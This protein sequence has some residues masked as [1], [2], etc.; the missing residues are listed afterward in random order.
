MKEN[1]S[2]FTV[3]E[4]VVIGEA[5]DVDVPVYSN[6]ESKLNKDDLIDL[7]IE[8]GVEVDP[9]KEEEKKDKVSFSRPIPV[10]KSKRF[11]KRKY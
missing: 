3:K 6:G 5:N 7:L 8:N 2:T 9:K 11:R 1:L 10:H 4:L